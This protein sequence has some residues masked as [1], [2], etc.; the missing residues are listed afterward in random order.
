MPRHK[1]AAKRMVTNE[2]RRARNASVKA[3]VKTLVKRVRT[4]TKKEELEASLRDAFQALDKAAKKGIFHPRTASRRK[5][6]LAK[7]VNRVAVAAAK[8]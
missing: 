3:H 4:E 8:S 6:R 7:H 5:S 2:K 1:S